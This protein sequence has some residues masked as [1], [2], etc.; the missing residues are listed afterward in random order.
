MSRYRLS[1]KDFDMLT[2]VKSLVFY[3]EQVNAE[4]STNPTYTKEQKRE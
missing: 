4:V 2:V 3:A 1:V